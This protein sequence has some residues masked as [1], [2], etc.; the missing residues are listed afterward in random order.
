MAVER[1]ISL[2]NDPG[3]HA[4]N[5]AAGQDVRQV[6]YEADGRVVGC[7][8]G[9]VEGTTFTSGH[10]APFGGL[11]LARDREAPAA[12]A[13]CIDHVLT[14][15]RASGIETVRIRSRP[16]YYSEADPL[17]AFTLLNRGFRVELCDLNHAVRLEGIASAEDYVERLR[18]SARRAVR[19]ALEGPFAFRRAKGRAEWHEA[20]A[21]LAENRRAKGRVLSL[22]REYLDR[23]RSAFPERIRM[24]L[25]ARAGT[26]CAAALVYRV[27]E[28]RDLVVAW[29]DTAATE[30]SPMNL[31]ALR[32]VEASLAAG[33]LSLD[34]GTSTVPGGE[35]GSLSANDGLVA[36]KTSVL[37]QP[38]LRLVLVHDGPSNSA[39]PATT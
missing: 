18:S 13:A 31:L 33:A 1:W 35:A 23:L 8:T 15:L 10:S 32:V 12:V 36:F 28:A 27:R 7:L 11:D 29:G 5:L 39:N 34:L 19:L 16:A 4:L 38:E 14:E 21:I 20:Y 9:V 30:P 25:L 37:A 6:A 22:T 2:F 24:F 26:P 17:V 3:F